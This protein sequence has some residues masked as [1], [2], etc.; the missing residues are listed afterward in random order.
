[1]L[2]IW[3]KNRFPDFNYTLIKKLNAFIDENLMIDGNESWGR[4]LV[5]LIRRKV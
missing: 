2:N 5:R 4:Q 1:M 3:V